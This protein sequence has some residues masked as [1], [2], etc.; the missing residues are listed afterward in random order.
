M[1]LKHGFDEDHNTTDTAVW[2]LLL[3]QLK[4]AL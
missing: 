2:P 4:N 1:A 3:F